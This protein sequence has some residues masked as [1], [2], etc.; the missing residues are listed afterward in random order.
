MS[1]QTPQQPGWGPPPGPQLPSPKRK[2]TGRNVALVVVG[3]L[4]LFAVIGALSGGNDTATTAPAAPATTASQDSSAAEP[5]TTEAPSQTGP[6]TAK[7]GETLQFEDSFGK[8]SADITV[9]HKKV[10]TGDEFIKPDRGFYV[11]LFVRVKAYQDGISVPQFY[12]LVGSKHFDSTFA[13]GFEP[14]LNVIGN[15]NKGET[16]EGW[17]VFDVPSRTGKAVMQEFLSEKAQ[18]TWSY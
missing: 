4:V 16:A 7:L 11:G 12:A 1:S 15:L 9:T 18:A 2:H 17:V 8:H 5:E 13:T 3:L 14:D 10:S 6:A